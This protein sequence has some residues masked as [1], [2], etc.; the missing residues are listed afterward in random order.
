[1][2]KLRVPKECHACGK[3]FE[4]QLSL[5]RKGFGKYCSQGCYGKTMAGKK[6][7][8]EVLIHLMKGRESL[9]KIQKTKEYREKVADSRRGDKSHFWRGGITA[10][11]RIIRGS[12][13]YKVW[14]ENV[15]LRDGFKCVM[16][17]SDKSI[18]ADHIKPFSDFKDLRFS[19]ENGRTLCFSCHKGTPTYG[20]EYARRKR[21]YLMEHPEVKYVVVKV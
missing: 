5:L 21:G 3:P 16:C 12:T 6:A 11:S 8:P 1:M 15:F 14:R 20:N 2:K 7:S 18:Q 4:A 10:Q 13:E 17:G 9:R 19:V